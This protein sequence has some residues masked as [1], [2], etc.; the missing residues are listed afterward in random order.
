MALRAI[1]TN[2]SRA[3]RMPSDATAPANTAVYAMKTARTGSALL[4]TGTT[5]SAKLV[6]HGFCNLA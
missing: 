3:L 1:V 4:A 2:A 6:H 5:S